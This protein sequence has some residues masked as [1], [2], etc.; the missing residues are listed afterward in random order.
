MQM[1]QNIAVLPKLF[2]GVLTKPKTSTDL[3][4][5]PIEEQRARFVLSP[6]LTEAYPEDEPLGD[7]WLAGGES[8]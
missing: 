5:I 8:V 3:R 6:E 7:A 4:N 1:C 2:T